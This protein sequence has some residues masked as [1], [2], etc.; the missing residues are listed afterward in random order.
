MLTSVELHHGSEQ[1][2]MVGRRRGRFPHTIPQGLPSMVPF[3]DLAPIAARH[4]N[5]GR[6]HGCIRGRADR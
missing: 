5:A 4:S 1:Q 2:V 6:A 3:D